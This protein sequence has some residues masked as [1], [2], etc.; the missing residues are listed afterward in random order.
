MS[1]PRRTPVSQAS[2]HKVLVSINKSNLGCVD[3]PSLHLNYTEKLRFQQRDKE[4]QNITCEHRK[5]SC[6]IFQGG[7]VQ[8]VRE[9][10]A[11]QTGTAGYT[12]RVL[13]A[14]PSTFLNGGDPYP[15]VNQKEDSRFA[16]LDSDRGSETHAV[17]ASGSDSHAHW[18]LS[19]FRGISSNGTCYKATCTHCATATQ[20]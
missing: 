8:A 12:K 13:P 9:Q 1:A 10:R 4:Q 14:V 15:P 3:D 6:D 20:P 17:D 16:H 2:P 7:S 19:T 18:Q 5:E 11:F